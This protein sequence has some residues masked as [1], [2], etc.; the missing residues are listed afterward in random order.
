ML[1]IYLS[2]VNRPPGKV[3]DFS[4]IPALRKADWSEQLTNVKNIIPR[5]NA[6]AMLLGMMFFTLLFFIPPL[7]EAS[8]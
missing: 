1:M 2:N 5:F 4:L 7:F 3:K 6:F 8:F